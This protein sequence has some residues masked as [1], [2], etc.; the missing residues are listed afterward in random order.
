MHT[1]PAVLI[2]ALLLGPAIALAQSD[3][4]T[5]TGAVK[6]TSGAVIPGVTVTARH[7]GTNEVRSVVSNT[8]GL[9]RITNLPRG[10]YEVKAEVQGFQ[11][12]NQTGVLVTVGET[13]R[14][15]FAMSVGSLTETVDVVSQASLVNTEEGRISNLVDEKRVSEL[16]LNGRN[17]FQLM[18]LQPGATGNPGNVVLGGSAGGNSAFV[19]GQRNRANNFLLDGTDNNDQ[20]TAGRVAVNPNVDM[21]QEFRVSSNNF[22]AEFGRN[23]ASVVNV[24]TKGGTNVL[25]GTAYEFL[26]NDAL[27]ARTVFAREVDPLR[28]NQFGGTV[29]G[30]IVKDRTFFFASYEG[31]RVTRGVTLVRT[32]E[33]PEFRQLVA[34]QFPNSIANFLFQNFPSP[35][36]TSNIR[37]T[38]RP[39]AGLATD[40]AANNPGVVTDP[41]YTPSGA[42]FRNVLQ[43]T[44]D[45]IPDIGTANIPVSEKIDGDQVSGRIDQEMGTGI[46]LLGRFLWDD[47]T[48]DDKQNI[49]RHEGFNQPVDEKGR[50]L[51]VGYTHVLSNSLV[52]EARFGYS[53]RKRG[54]LANNEGV[55]SIGFDDG[56]VAFGNF[57]TNPAF[58][59]QKTLHWV[60]T[61]SWNRGSHAL[62]SVG[63]SGTSATTPT[64]RS[65]A[66]ATSSSIST[67]SRWTRS[68]ASRSWASIQERD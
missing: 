34:D 41:N 15:D 20:F 55:P 68:R 19:N 18:E 33:T 6:D 22:S 52:N 47:R 64:S 61:V 9:Y 2:C 36:P 10:T 30:P 5:L 26:R 46:R 48:Q 3:T 44:P 39:V 14:L 62:S 35:A 21:I 16:P 53:Y 66:V 1:F 25:H 31:L 23:S 51:T 38:G 28:Y 67:T 17:V 29:G 32:V 11:T 40:S 8:D 12:I 56:V 58:F 65:G 37:D 60:D 49:P 24:V 4:A 59:E 42:L 63:R 50:N 45:G 43:A 7:T 54:L 27:D 57:A 13:V